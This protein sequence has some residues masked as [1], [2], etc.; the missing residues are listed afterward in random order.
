VELERTGVTLDGGKVTISALAYADDAALT[1]DTKPEASRAVSAIR[2]GFRKDGD[3][4]VSQP[5]TEAMQVAR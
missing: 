3:K 4:E 2:L 1:C 5:K